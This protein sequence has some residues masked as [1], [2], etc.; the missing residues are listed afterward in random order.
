[1]YIISAYLAVI[2]LC[3]LAIEAKRLAVVCNERKADRMVAGAV[4]NLKL[5]NQ[6]LNQLHLEE[7]GVENLPPGDE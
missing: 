2:L 5:A 1:V 4:E 7:L 3:Q 6:R